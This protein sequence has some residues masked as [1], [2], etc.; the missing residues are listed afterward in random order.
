MYSTFLYRQELSEMFRHISGTITEVFSGI[1]K[2]R[3]PGIRSF[4][5]R[6]CIFDHWMIWM[7]WLSLVY[8]VVQLQSRLLEAGR[9]QTDLQSQFDQS[10][11]LLQETVTTKLMLINLK[12][13][14]WIWTF[15]IIKPIFVSRFRTIANVSL[16]WQEAELQALQR[17]SAEEENVWKNKLSEAEQQKQT[18]RVW[19]RV[20]KADTDCWRHVT[21]SRYHMFPLKY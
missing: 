8:L 9:T 14:R 18:V 7:I 10:S 5:E 19:Y 4:V 6:R 16:V 2:L 3:T 17:R 13:I 12:Q 21:Y 15:S 20:Y 11:K 1:L